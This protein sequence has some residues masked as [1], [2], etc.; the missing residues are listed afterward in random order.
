[1]PKKD[2]RSKTSPINGRKGGRPILEATKLRA[3]LIKKAEENAEQLAQV[4]FDKAIQGDLPSIKEMLDRAIGKALQ[5]TDLTT[6]GKEMPRPILEV[7]MKQDG[8]SS[9]N[10]DQEA[11]SA[12]EQN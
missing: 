11:V 5:R 3:A 10:G 1:M 8:V 7:V 6:D 9:D 4:L 2:G 12:E